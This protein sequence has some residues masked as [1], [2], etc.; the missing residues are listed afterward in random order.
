LRFT[1]YDFLNSEEVTSGEFMAAGGYRT[2]HFGKVGG[3]F[4][5]HYFLKKGI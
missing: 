2:A 4:I 3:F 5:T 1:G